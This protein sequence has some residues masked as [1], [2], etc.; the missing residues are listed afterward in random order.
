VRDG[1]HTPEAVD[2]LLERLPAPGDYVVVASILRDKDV[3]AILARLARAGETLVATR[4]SNERAL[5]AEAVAERARSVFTRVEIA[6]DPATALEL[7]RTF[8]RP[9]LVTGSLYLL[10]DLAGK[11]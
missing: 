1:A 9:V 5:P 8:G 7:A 2:W 10:A 11:G 4:S 6:N 3:P